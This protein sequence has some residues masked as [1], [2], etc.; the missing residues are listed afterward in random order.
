MRTDKLKKKLKEV[1]EDAIYDEALHATEIK[2]CFDNVV[3]DIQK[4]AN[5]IRNRTGYIG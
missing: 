3:K 2:K 1:V 5:D 4:E